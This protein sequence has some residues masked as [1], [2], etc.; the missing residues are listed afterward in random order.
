MALGAR[1][2]AGPDGMQGFGRISLPASLP[3]STPGPG[4]GPALPPKAQAPG[5]RLQV[6]DMGAFTEEGQRKEMG[7][8][9]AT[10]QG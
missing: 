3:L 4:Q 1:L 5:M 6:A 7:G 9:T 10:G 2:G 8:L